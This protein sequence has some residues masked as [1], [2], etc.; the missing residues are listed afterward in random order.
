MWI[1]YLS[2]ALAI[3]VF[4]LEIINNS[5]KNKCFNLV[6]TEMKVSRENAVNVCKSTI[7]NVKAKITNKK[8]KI[9]FAPIIFDNTLTLNANSSVKNFILLKQTWFKPLVLNNDSWNIAFFHTIGHELGHKHKEP[10]PVF[11]GHSKKQFVNWVRECRADFFGIQFVQ[12]NF[13]VSRSEVLD[14]F[15]LKRNHNNSIKVNT[16][17]DSL[18]HPSWDFRYRLLCENIVFDSKVIKAI[19]N[20]LGFFNE[21]YIEKMILEACL[22]VVTKEEQI[23]VCKEIHNY[24][25]DILPTV[26][27]DDMFAKTTL[28]EIGELYYNNVLEN[29]ENATE[30]FINIVVKNIYSRATIQKREDCYIKLC[31]LVGLKIV[32]TSI[33]EEFNSKFEQVFITKYNIVISQYNQKIR[34]I[35]TEINEIEKKIKQICEKSYQNIVG[36][37]SAPE[38]ELSDCYNQKNKLE[39]YKEMLDYSIQYMR[40]RIVSFFDISDVGNIEHNKKKV[41]LEICKYNSI[42][43]DTIFSPYL[44][45]L[46]ITEDEIS[47]D[48]C[49]YFKIKTYPIIEQIREKIR[50]NHS[51]EEE[52][53]TEL[54]KI[55][56]IDALHNFKEFDSEQ[57]LT[58]L[59]K[60]LADFDI[61]NTVKQGIN[62]SVCVRKRKLILE[63]A[64]ALYDQ[65]KYGLFNTIVP[66]QIEG[67]FD[68]YLLDT[69]IF[70]RFSKMKI[71]HDAVL[72]KKIDYLKESPNSIYPEAVKYF[73]YYFNSAIRNRI[74]H[75]RYIGSLDS[76]KDEIFAKELLLDLNTLIYMFQRN[77]E[78]E[79]MARFINKYKGYYDKVIHSDENNCFEA[80]FNDL[81]GQKII[82]EYDNVEIVD[83]MQA[84]Y[85][86]I[87][88]YY[89]NIYNQTIGDAKLY[90]LRNI[91]LSEDFWKYVLNRLKSVTS[92][93]YDYLLISKK[94]P[95][96][97]YALFKCNLSP[98]TRDV[99]KNVSKE[100]NIIMNLQ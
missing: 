5:K 32:P 26:I 65:G 15:N 22:D 85:W 24:I 79:K 54:S 4:V 43:I 77:S 97:I 87:N 47:R 18:S 16:K 11:F 19:A 45:Y 88:P 63:E 84:I 6:A 13:S 8:I 12:S 92:Q 57:Y 9:A 82:F 100:I 59:S 76:T 71:Y 10:H 28:F 39:C 74:A 1:I 86:L 60:L 50:L 95:S 93:G 69:T 78:T 62:K 58:C 29:V 91:F 83:S 46:E 35:E 27:L 14:A 3:V 36:D 61:L 81:I 53:S 44:D 64:I 90:E 30:E 51:S 31:D 52:V 33:I 72:R 80:L 55:P 40:D 2:F 42:D 68:D 38:K 67:L 37:I 96:I 89:E 98:V 25:F 34:S 20:E 7:N 17:S 41:L 48:Y 49:V 23:Y 94:T 75:G 73:K 66:I 99:L 70:M 21:K 56:S